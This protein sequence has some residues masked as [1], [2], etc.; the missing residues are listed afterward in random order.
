MAPAGNVSRRCG[1]VDWV[2]RY[3]EYV[4]CI[5]DRR[6][7]NWF[8][9][10]RETDIALLSGRSF[11]TLQSR[12]VA[13]IDNVD[14]AVKA[15]GKKDHWHWRCV[16]GVQRKISQDGQAYNQNSA[17]Q[18]ESAPRYKRREMLLLTYSII[19]RC[20]M[21]RRM[22]RKRSDYHPSYPAPVLNHLPSRSDR[23][24]Q[25]QDQGIPRFRRRSPKDHLCRKDSSGYLVCWTTQHQGKGLFGCHG[26]Q[27]A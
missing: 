24:R 27:G 21:L 7:L 2:T 10:L 3:L 17:E 15:T 20:S 1:R 26:D 18:G 19:C 16:C 4:H 8:V 5:A 11:V 22:R 12:T 13:M 14:E 25:V 6:C 9:C 23:R